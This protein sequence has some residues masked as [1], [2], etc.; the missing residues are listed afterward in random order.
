MAGTVSGIMQKVTSLFKGG[1]DS[2][3]RDKQEK[4]RKESILPSYPWGKPIEE[5][6]KWMLDQRYWQL[7]YEKLQLHRKWFRNHLF[8]CGYHDSV[9]SDIGFS[10]DSIGVNSADNGFVSNYYRSYIRYGAAMYVQTAPEFI[11]QPTSPDSESQGVA[12][13][14]RATLDI[15]KENIGYDAIRAREAINLRLDRK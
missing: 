8:Y 9:L 14:A 4:Q 2:L 5:R 3:V 11:A 7:Q 10:F 13:A 1:S 12:S 15:Q 6:I